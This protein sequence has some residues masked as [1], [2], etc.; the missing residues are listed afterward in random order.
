LARFCASIL[1]SRK[2]MRVEDGLYLNK[3]QDVKLFFRR[4]RWRDQNRRQSFVHTEYTLSTIT[5]AEMAPN[6]HTKPTNLTSRHWRPS[7]YLF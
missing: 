7:F 6:E 4:K 2:I 5:G 3:N 1:L